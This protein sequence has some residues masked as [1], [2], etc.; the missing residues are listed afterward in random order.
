MNWISKIV[1]MN[2]LFWFSVFLSV[3]L[4][5]CLTQ[6]GANTGGTVHGPNLLAI[7]VGLLAALLLAAIVVAPFWVIF[8]K[9]GFQPFLSVLTL[10]PP[11]NLALLYFVAFSEWKTGPA[12]KT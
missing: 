7:G 4:L 8:K 1:A 10:I 11:V 6:G 12:Q 3:V 9:A 5:W 2:F